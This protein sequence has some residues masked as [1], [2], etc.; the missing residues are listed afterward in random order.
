MAIDTKPRKNGT[1]RG[2]STPDSTSDV[3]VSRDTRIMVQGLL[4]AVIASG[5]SPK[6]ILK[7]TQHAY[8]VALY[9]ARRASGVKGDTK[10]EWKE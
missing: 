10:P 4:Q 6:Y 5:V 7:E 8:N 3:E 2:S 1:R 9:L